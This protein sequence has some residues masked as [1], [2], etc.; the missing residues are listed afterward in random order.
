MSFLLIVD[1]KSK[2]HEAVLM[3][4]LLMSQE[5]ELHLVGFVQQALTPP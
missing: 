4:L 2:V 1:E 3:R 5:A